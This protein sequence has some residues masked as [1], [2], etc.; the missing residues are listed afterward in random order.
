MSV[1]LGPA[2]AP[3][4]PPIVINHTPEV[5]AVVSMCVYGGSCVSAAFVFHLT[6]KVQPPRESSD[7]PLMLMPPSRLCLCVPACVESFFCAFT[8]I[9]EKRML[10]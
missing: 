7:R 4:P 8:V 1:A 3:A 2:E 9:K 5:D 10:L 6:Q